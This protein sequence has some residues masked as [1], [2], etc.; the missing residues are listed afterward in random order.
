MGGAQYRRWLKNGVLG[1]CLAATL[2]GGCEPSPPAPS[3]TK[4]SPARTAKRNRLWAWRTAQAQVHKRFPEKTLTFP[5]EYWDAFVDER[6][7]NYY[8]I[9]AYADTQDDR[10][11]PIR[12]RFE[13]V[14]RRQDNQCKPISLSILSQEEI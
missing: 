11:A 5:N 14:L 2:L 6:E 4:E 10:G 9:T 7:N 12:I 1:L 13:C 8:V 3:K